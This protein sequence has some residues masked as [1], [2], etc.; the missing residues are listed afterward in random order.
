M[1]DRP[2]VCVLLRSLRFTTYWS[3]SWPDASVT[4]GVAVQ[5]GAG[6]WW[7]SVKYSILCSP[8][9][10]EIGVLDILGQPSL[11]KARIVG[12]CVRLPSRRRATGRGSSGSTAIPPFRHSRTHRCASSALPAGTAASGDDHMDAYRFAAIFREDVAHPHARENSRQKTRPIAVTVRH[13]E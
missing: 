9:P 12:E 2:P 1:P 11:D 7:R 4:L 8:I 6:A 3:S 13:G 10:T 5:S